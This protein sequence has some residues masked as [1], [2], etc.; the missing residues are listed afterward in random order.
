MNDPVISIENLRRDFGSVKA[1]DNLNLEAT[2]GSILALLGPN[3]AGKTTLLRIVM[4]LIEPTG[5]QA[6]VLGRPAWPY[7]YKQCGRIAYVGDRCEP[8][9]WATPGLLVALQASTSMR[10][11]RALFRD[12]CARRNIDP[13]RHYGA[14]SKGQRRWILTSLALASRPELILLDEPA[15]GLDPAARRDLYDSLRNYVTECDAAAVV[16]THVIADVERIADDVAIIDSGRL[17]FSAPLEDLREQV[18]QVEIPGGIALPKIDKAISI[19]G[20]VRSGDMQILWIRHDGTSDEALREKLG[21]GANIRTIG[22]E[23]IYLAIAEHR[24]ITQ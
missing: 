21:T 20:S 2:K 23:E 10:F 18:R 11:N 6:S 17:I 12:L 9:N 8:P 15:D 5:G 16:A 1:L 19:L 14:M 3:G 4:G 13:R 7:S 24:H 22:L